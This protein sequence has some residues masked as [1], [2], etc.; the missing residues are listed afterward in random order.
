[1]TPLPPITRSGAQHAAQHELAKQIYHRNS[2]PLAVRGL[3]AF[4]HLVDRILGSAVGHAPGGDLGALALVVI[5]VVLVVLVIRRVGVPRRAAAVGAVLAGGEPVTAAEHRTR[6]ER[7]AAAGD[8]HT[9]VIERMRAIARELEERDIVTGR[10]GRTATELAREAGALLPDLADR[11]EPAAD[12][13]NRVAYGGGRPE[14]DSLAIL[15]AADEA[16]Q[17][18]ARPRA[19]AR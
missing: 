2:D 7:A 10:A 19:V 4:G 13:F 16:V 1:M 12:T 15:A 8:W 17:A 11:L 3:R 18:T 5:V 9:A 6:A 14:P